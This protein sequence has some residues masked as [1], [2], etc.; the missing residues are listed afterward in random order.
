MA[1]QD[2]RRGDGEVGTVMFSEPQEINSGFVGQHPLF[3]QIAQYLCLMQRP[4]VRPLRDIAE[5]IEAEFEGFG[6][7]RFHFLLPW[8]DFLRLFLTP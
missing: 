7:E 4:A 3:D 2:F 1:E 6:H 5:G 8:P